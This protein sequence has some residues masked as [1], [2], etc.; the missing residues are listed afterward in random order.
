[1]ILVD[2]S[3]WIDH[4][5][6]GN[7]DLSAALSSGEILTHEFI[8]GELACGDLRNRA[9]LMADFKALPTAVVARHDEVLAMVEL[10]RL[11]GKGLGWI[12]AHLIASC[13]ILGAKLWTAD[14]A[15]QRA[16][17]ALGLSYPS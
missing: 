16:A 3:V 6:Y 15:L 17:R 4:L 2:S 8:I 14:K 12:D 11:S 5:R 7:A 1:M 9:E 10:R 13:L